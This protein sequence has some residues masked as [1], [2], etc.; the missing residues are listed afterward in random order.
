MTASMQHLVHEYLDERRSLGFA[1]TIPGSQLLAFARFAAASGHRGPLTRQLITSWARDEAKRATPLTWAK[2]LEVVRPF[3]K[4]RALIE[5]GTYV[6]EADTF[7]RSRRRLAPHL[8][9]DQEIVDL[10]AAA[11]RLS[12]KGTLRPATYRALFGLIAA[13]GLRVSEALRLKCADVDLEIG[14][15]HV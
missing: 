4:H 9:T 14:R 5:P 12:P 3:A 7:G 11:G 6:P 2:R 10:L 1:L 8:Y 15:A 13:T